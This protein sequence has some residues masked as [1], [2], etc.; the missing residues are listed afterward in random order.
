MNNIYRMQ[1][2][3]AP[4]VFTWTF[5]G[6]QDYKVTQKFKEWE[7]RLPKLIHRKMRHHLVFSLAHGRSK[8]VAWKT[9]KK[10]TIIVNFNE[11]HEWNYQLLQR[12]LPECPNQG[13]SK[14]NAWPSGQVCSTDTHLRLVPDGVQGMILAIQPQSS[15]RNHPF[16]KYQPSKILETHEI[17]KKSLR[18]A[19]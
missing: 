18:T 13:L 2:W 11:K 5:Q 10:N 14:P 12:P 4:E 3:K 1:L 15:V 16:T 9:G 6:M 19:E 7:K 17:T 8:D